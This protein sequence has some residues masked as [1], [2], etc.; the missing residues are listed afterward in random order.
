MLIIYLLP[1]SLEPAQKWSNKIKGEISLQHNCGENKG[2][3]GVGTQ[4]RGVVHQYGGVIGG[5]V[6]TACH[7]RTHTQ[8]HTHM[9]KHTHTPHNILPQLGKELC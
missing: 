4:N 6:L 3:G 1:I 9:N 2:W 8:P 7:A 5:R